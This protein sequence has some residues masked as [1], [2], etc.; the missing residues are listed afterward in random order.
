MNVAVTVNLYKYILPIIYSVFG[1]FPNE[2]IK[3][4]RIDQAHVYNNERTER[5]DI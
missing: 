5:S 1:R 3:Q 2:K 4:I